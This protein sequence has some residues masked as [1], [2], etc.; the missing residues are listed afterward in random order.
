MER[1]S[2]SC[3]TFA[4]TGQAGGGRG[5]GPERSTRFSFAEDGW[6]VLGQQSLD[7]GGVQVAVAVGATGGV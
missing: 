5:A 3:Q 4:P 7:G 2:S 1:V 6:R